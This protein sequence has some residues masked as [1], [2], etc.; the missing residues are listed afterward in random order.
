MTTEVLHDILYSQDVENIKQ[1]SNIKNCK[2]LGMVVQTT[3]LMARRPE[4]EDS[5]THP[6]VR[7]CP[8]SHLRT[9]HCPLPHK[10][11][12]MSSHQT[13]LYFNPLTHEPLGDTTSKL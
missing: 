3:H 8:S 5:D 12:T 1:R 10:G 11:S 13:G 4:E 9:S 6:A 7:E 2:G